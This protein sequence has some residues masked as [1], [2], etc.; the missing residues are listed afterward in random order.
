MARV[1]MGQSQPPLPD[2]MHVPATAVQIVIPVFNQLDYTRKCLASLRQNTDATVPVLVIDNG[3]TD[4]TADFLSTEKHLAVIRNAENLGCAAAWN[5]GVERAG[6]AGWVAILNNDILVPPGWLEG[7]LQ[8]AA[9][10]GLDIICPA[11]RE[12][13]L[14]YDFENHARE[15]IRRAGA[16]LRPGMAHGICFLVRQRVFDAIGGFDPNFRVGQYED[17]DFFQ[18]AR[19]AGFKLAVT[20]RSFIHHF[21][22]ATQNSLR[23]DNGVA[24]YEARNRAYYRSKWQLAWHQRALQRVKSKAQLAWWR[25][26]ERRQCGHALHERWRAR[27][28]TYE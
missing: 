25:A 23:Q 14:N 12:G 28:L 6:Y 26:Q 17:A 4:G 24:A 9:E 2:P 18:R 10:N 1:N 15:F 13:L 22:S 7:L 5:Q 21:G 16:I 19:L 8:A 3:S 11:L 27:A 20:G